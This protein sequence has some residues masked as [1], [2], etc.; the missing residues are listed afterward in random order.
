MCV[1]SVKVTPQCIEMQEG[2]WFYGARAEV[3]PA[4]SACTSVT[5]RSD[6]PLVASVNANTGYIYGVEV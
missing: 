2:S 6:S 5:W 1:T 4:D 3:S